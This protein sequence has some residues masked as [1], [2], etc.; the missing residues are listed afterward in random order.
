MWLYGRATSMRMPDPRFHTPLGRKI[1][2]EGVGRRE[3][4]KGRK[5]N[6]GEKEGERKREEER[7]GRKC[8]GMHR[9]T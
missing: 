3:R 7:R 2:G 5:G 8:G 9:T 6:E 4:T 1:V